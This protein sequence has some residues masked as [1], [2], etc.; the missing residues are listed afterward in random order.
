MFVI[1]IFLNSEKEVAQE[2]HFAKTRLA[3]DWLDL[4][5]SLNTLLVCSHPVL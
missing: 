5:V 1:E 3:T 2:V 4:T